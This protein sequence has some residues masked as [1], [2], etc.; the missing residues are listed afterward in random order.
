M[1]EA[2]YHGVPI[3]GLPFGQDQFANLNRAVDDGYGLKLEWKDLNK[4]TF[5]K[6]IDELL[7]NP[8]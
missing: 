2:I 8:K 5:G 1:Q 6:A 7:Q 4:E 3:L